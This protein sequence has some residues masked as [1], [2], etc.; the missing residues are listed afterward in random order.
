MRF[1]RN[2]GNAHSV[3]TITEKMCAS[4]MHF[5]LKPMDA[6]LRQNTE[7]PNACCSIAGLSSRT[8]NARL[9][10]K[11]ARRASMTNG[12]FIRSM[13]DEDIMENLT[14]GICDLMTMTGRST[15]FVR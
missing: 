15:P 4:T 9:A 6:R 11:P 7:S 3:G 12:D 2:T 13:T 8:R 5:A 14:P 1:R 10:E